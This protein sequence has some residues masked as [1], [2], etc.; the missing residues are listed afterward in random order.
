[1]T[2]L[3][4]NFSKEVLNAKWWS[5]DREIDYEVFWNSDNVKTK[6]EYPDTV[7]HKVKRY[8]AS[9]KERGS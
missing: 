8:I 3:K 7:G 2:E 4:T 1:V 9:G 6:M 5:A